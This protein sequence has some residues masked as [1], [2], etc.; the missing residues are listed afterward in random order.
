MLGTTVK[1]KNQNKT[2]Q[3][4]C[5]RNY[6]QN[7]LVHLELLSYKKINNN[8]KKTTC[9]TSNR[10]ESNPVVFYHDLTPLVKNNPPLRK[11]TAKPIPQNKET[12][13]SANVFGWEIKR[14][15]TPA[16]NQATPILERNSAINFFWPADNFF[17][18]NNNSKKWFVVKYSH[19]LAWLEGN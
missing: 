18:K 6:Y 15:T 9:Q 3:S 14:F 16:T 2:Y 19:F 8:Q 13:S 11:A 5:Q 1:G 12:A 10:Q 17:I 4:D 7:S